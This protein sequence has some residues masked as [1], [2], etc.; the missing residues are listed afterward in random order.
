M[1]FAPLGRA[2]TVACAV[3]GACIALLAGCA[4]SGSI[5]PQ[6]KM[7][8]AAQVAERLQLPASCGK[9]NGSSTTACNTVKMAVFAP[10]HSARVSKAVMLNAFSFHRSFRPNRKSCSICKLI[11]RGSQDV[12]KILQAAL[13]L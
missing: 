13:E 12:R 5:A 11:R 6:E 8:D 4:S 2:T 10:M 3:A 1:R 9:G 7:P